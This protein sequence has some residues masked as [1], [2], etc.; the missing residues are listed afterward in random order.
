LYVHD[1]SNSGI[2]ELSFDAFERSMA[3]N[4]PGMSKKN[5]IRVFELPDEL[6]PELGVAETG[7]LNKAQ[8]MLR[9]PVKILGIPAMRKLGEEIAS[10]DN[11][12]SFRHLVTYATVPPVLPETANRSD[13]MRFV[14]S[15]VLRKLGENYSRSKWVR[16]AY[17]FE[18]SG[19]LV[20]E[21]CEHALRAEGRPCSDLMFRIAEIEEEAYSILEN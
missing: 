9:P 19:N 20:K 6:P 21:L 1:C 7:F 3:V 2:Q 5:T 17:M 15:S 14:Q 13:G 4:V 18:E 16:A 8:M 10:W 12:A 11:Q